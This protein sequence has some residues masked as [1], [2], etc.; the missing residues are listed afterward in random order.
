MI[1]IQTWRPKSSWADFDRLFSQFAENQESA[2]TEVWAP[3]CDLFESENEITINLDLPGL[4]KENIDIQLND[5]KTLVVRGERTVVKPADE[6]VKVHRTE[7]FSGQLMRTFSLPYSVDPAKI[8][9]T[10][11]DGVLQIVLHKP[12]TL[13]PKKIEIKSE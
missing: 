5:A 2:Q 3:N 9:A 12:E 13:K 7:R 10:F 4:K 8:S 6:K 11:N 1:N